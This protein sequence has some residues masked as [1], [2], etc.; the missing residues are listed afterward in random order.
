MPEFQLPEGR[1]NG[2]QFRFSGRWRGFQTEPGQGTLT[3][4]IEFRGRHRSAPSPTAH[5]QGAVI[6]TPVMAGRSCDAL[7]FSIFHCDILVR[8]PNVARRQ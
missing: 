5:F 7:G 6:D 2:Q 1:G 4:E 8:F 3:T